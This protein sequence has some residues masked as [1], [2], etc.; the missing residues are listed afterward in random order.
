VPE[1]QAVV[2]VC[3]MKQKIGCTALIFDDQ[4]TPHSCRSGKNIFLME[5]KWSTAI[6]G[7]SQ[8]DRPPLIASGIFSYKSSL[9]VLLAAI[10]K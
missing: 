6:F 5:H 9:D 3:F 10:A 1:I 8:R 2:E 7:I 4:K